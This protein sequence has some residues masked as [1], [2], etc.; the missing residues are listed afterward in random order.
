MLKKRI[1]GGKGGPGG[2]EEVPGAT[3][4][5]QARLRREERRGQPVEQPATKDIRL[6]HEPSD[7]SETPTWRKRRWFNY[8]CFQWPRFQTRFKCWSCSPR[9]LNLLFALPGALPWVWM[10]LASPAWACIEVIKD[11]SVCHRGSQAPRERAGW[12]LRLNSHCWQEP[13]WLLSR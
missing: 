5:P 4:K 9:V 8:Y 6:S 1:C 7:T 13:S 11:K 2:C 12:H 10:E 3:S